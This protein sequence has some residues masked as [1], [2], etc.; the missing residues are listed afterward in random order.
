MD[1]N[2]LK[3][4]EYNTEDWI[5]CTLLFGFFFFLISEWD[6]SF[7]KLT[8]KAALFI[9]INVKLISYR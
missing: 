8:L 7:M 9:H 6:I 2:L 4:L 3:A 5:A 1:S